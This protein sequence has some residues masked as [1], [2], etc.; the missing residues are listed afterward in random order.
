MLAL[1]LALALAAQV[2]TWNH[3]GI[4]HAR[5]CATTATLTAFE[6]SCGQYYLIELAIE[7]EVLT[8]APGCQVYA[9]PRCGPTSGAG[10]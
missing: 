8:R 1:A 6:L 9:R 7:L 5:P 10:R 4:V 3:E 2:M